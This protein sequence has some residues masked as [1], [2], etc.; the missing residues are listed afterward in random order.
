MK[1]LTRIQKANVNLFMLVMAAS[2]IGNLIG[3]AGV[4]YFSEANTEFSSR[5]EKLLEKL[6]ILE[7]LQRDQ[8]YYSKAIEQSHQEKQQLE[9]ALKFHQQMLEKTST[10]STITESTI[11]QSQ[12]STK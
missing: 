10:Q 6:E 1:K 4:N 9:R 7:K 8:A 12:P 3:Y 2:I 11:T 5:D